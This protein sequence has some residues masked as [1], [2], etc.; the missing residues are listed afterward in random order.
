MLN[1]EDFNTLRL[2]RSDG[3]GSMTFQKLI[4]FFQSATATIKNIDLFKNRKPI[5]LAKQEDIE[6]EVE[7]C[8]KF[9]AEILTY[10]NPKYPKSLKL[11]S[12]FPPIINVIGNSDLL[13]KKN[14]AI[15]G[16][17][18]ASAN[19][20]NFARKISKEIG[21]NGYIIT[22]GMATGIDTS[23][24]WGAIESGT[25]AVLGGGIDNI[26]PKDNEDLYRKIRDNGCI[27][28]EIPIHSP[29]KSENF[30]ARNRIITG[31]SLGVVVVEAAY[32]S[33]TINTVRLAAEQG[34]EIMV[35][36][37]N[38]YDPRCDG[39]NALIKDGAM[40]V[41]NSDDVLYNVNNDYKPPQNKENEIINDEEDIAIETD[42]NDIEKL[43]LDKL[44]Y[45]P[46][47]IEVLARDINVDVGV[48]N[49]HITDLE[50]NGDIVIEFGKIRRKN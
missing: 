29:P 11:I 14:I 5:I 7:E 41:L 30:P 13:D 16:A 49:S 19:G 8:K 20:C 34:K 36:P 40:V 23:A 17:R 38:P 9:G 2:I 48:L 43:L 21:S 37:G 47:A 45:T 31:I 44:N 33:G 1:E 15:I 50:L 28:S 35:C 18:N 46:I 32:K 26:Y 25:I 22:S 27:V 6:I 12:D 42:V 24:H 4:T 3:V 39:S 10:L